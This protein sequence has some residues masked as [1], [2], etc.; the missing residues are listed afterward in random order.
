MLVGREENQPWAFKF[1]Y[2]RIHIR[3]GNGLTMGCYNTSIAAFRT[4]NVVYILNIP[5]IVHT[6]KRALLTATPMDGSWNGGTMATQ[7][8]VEELG[9]VW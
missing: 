8:E 1:V 6:E 5:Y 4:R 9:F 2:Q 7:R 3:H